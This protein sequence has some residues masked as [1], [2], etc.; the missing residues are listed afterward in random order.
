[1]EVSPALPGRWAAAGAEKNRGKA[2]NMYRI[3]LI[4]PAYVKLGVK[5]EKEEKENCSRGIF[6]PCFLPLS[7]EDF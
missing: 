5:R 3:R 7:H 6:I 4:I 1:M 2:T